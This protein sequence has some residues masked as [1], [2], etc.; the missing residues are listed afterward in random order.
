MKKL[1]IL[2]GIFGLSV[3]MLA[4]QSDKETTTTQSSTVSSSSQ[5]TATISDEHS[6]TDFY[7]ELV[8]YE[9]RLDV[10][11]TS[12][13]LETRGYQKIS[14]LLL[15]GEELTETITRD[16]ILAVH[17]TEQPDRVY[18]NYFEQLITTLLVVTNIREMIEDQSAINLN[19][20]F[21]PNDDS[22]I[23][24]EFIYS[25]SGYILIDA[26]YRTEHFYL[27]LGTN[28]DLLEYQELHYYYYSSMSI[29]SND[30][31]AMSFN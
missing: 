26:L 31:L 7:N 30:D 20:P 5:T 22:S 6:I 2:L 25:E 4:C 8:S 24:Y 3:I 18:S 9:N 23:T 19:E 13:Q 10:I 16:E 29:G 1:A 28:D 17:Y 11:V 12:M 27:K 15:E 14:P 21:N